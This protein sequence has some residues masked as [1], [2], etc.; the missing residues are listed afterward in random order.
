MMKKIKFV[1][2]VLISVIS[3][4]LSKVRIIPDERYQLCDGPKLGKGD[5]ARGKGVDIDVDYQLP[6]ENT[7]IVNGTYTF[8]I[9]IN[10]PL[11][12]RITGEKYELA[13]WHRRLVQT[14]TDACKELF[15]PMKMYYPYFKN[16]KRCP[17]KA[18][19]S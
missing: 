6:D 8:K 7:V 14:I 5:V 11:F 16:Q 17:L 9:S 18:G 15:D 1:L 13:G 2:L 4:G 3:E 12:I 19:V 10:S